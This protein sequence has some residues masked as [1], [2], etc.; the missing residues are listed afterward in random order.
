[1]GLTMSQTAMLRSLLQVTIIPLQNL[2][3]KLSISGQVATDAG[4]RGGQT[5]GVPAGGGGGG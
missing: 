1:M 2:N 4:E 3:L 5:G